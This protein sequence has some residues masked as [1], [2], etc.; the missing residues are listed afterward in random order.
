[1]TVRRLSQRQV[2]ML[3]GIDHSVLSRLLQGKR[4]MSYATAARLYRALDQRPVGGIAGPFGPMTPK[5]ESDASRPRPTHRR[6]SKGISRFQRLVAG[7]DRSALYSV[8]VS[9]VASRR[10]SRAFAAPLRGCLRV[11]SSN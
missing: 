11:A 4:S 6:V 9:R 2:A 10:V 5:D 1:M 3:S 7:A 8:G